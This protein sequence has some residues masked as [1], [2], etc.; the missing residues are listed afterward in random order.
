MS[1]DEILCCG[2]KTWRDLDEDDRM[3]PL[4]CYGCGELL[5]IKKESGHLVYGF[6]TDDGEEELRALQDQI[7]AAEEVRATAHEQVETPPYVA[8]IFLCDPENPER[9]GG[10]GVSA[11]TVWRIAD[12]RWPTVDEIAEALGHWRGDKNDGADRKLPVPRFHV[13]WVTAKDEDEKM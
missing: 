1:D 9:S 7:C 2:C 10:I 6:H 4:Y 8:H 12:D 3:G 5:G 11:G 13:E